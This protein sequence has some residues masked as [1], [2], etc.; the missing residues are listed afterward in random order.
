[1]DTRIQLAEREREQEESNGSIQ[2]RVQTEL[3][4]IL[5]ENFR[6]SYARVVMEEGS[7]SS[8]LML[9]DVAMH[10]EDLEELG[11]PQ[12]VSRLTTWPHRLLLGLQ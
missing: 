3:H 2:V 1:M 11:L 4:E 5:E 9:T 12:E 10:M 6:H 8:H 7:A